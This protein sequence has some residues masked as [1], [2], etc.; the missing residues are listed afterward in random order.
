MDI[1][2]QQLGSDTPIRLTRDPADERW[3]AFSPDGTKIAF[4]TERNGGGIEVVPALGGEPRHIVDGG[5]RP[6]F[7][8]DGNWIV[9]WVGRV[10]TSLGQR[11]DQEVFVVP[12]AGG[13]PRRIQPDFLT[14]RYPVWSPDGKYLLFAGW[15]DGNAPPEESFDWWVTPLDGGPAVKTGAAGVLRRAGLA[16]Y[17]TPGVWTDNKV[18]LSAR[19]GDGTSLWEVEIAPGT[20][21]VSG[22]PTRLTATTG[23]DAE[24]FVATDGTLLYASLT[25]NTDIWSLPLD[26]DRGK[27]RGELQPLIRNAAS[28]IS[29]SVTL[30]GKNWCLQ[31]DGQQRFVADGCRKGGCN[32]PDDNLFRG[33]G[34]DH[35]EWVDGLI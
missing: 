6:R 9:Y 31:P 7:S 25:E 20:W 29:P 16:P 23:L 14:A 26:A 2:V 24:P 21:Q 34:P 13:I 5:Q 32:S 15:R 27:S 1:W 10:R 35:P 11:I 3:P 28:D 19:L 12:A 33:V 30:D 22:G 17:L 4:R 18:V 8:P